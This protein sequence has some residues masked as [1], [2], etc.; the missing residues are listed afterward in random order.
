MTPDQLTIRR[1]VPGDA[2][3]IARHR[4][5]MFMDMGH[6]DPE[7]LDVMESAC[8]D[9]VRI[10]L[11]SEEYLAWLAVSAEGA[12]VSGAGLWIQPA[13]PRPVDM[14]GRRG[15]ILN[16]YTYP[17]YRRRGLA[18]QLVRRTVKWCRDQ[19]INYV[20]LHATEAGRPIYEKLGF[21]AGNEMYLWVKD[22]T[23][24]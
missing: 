16:V 22:L 6:T 2:P 15:Y 12:A 5:L 18:G 13:M 11:A 21:K 4:R 20:A 7:K 19:G 14:C 24:A 1:A 23:D 3:A 10:R 8:V 17:E 9:W